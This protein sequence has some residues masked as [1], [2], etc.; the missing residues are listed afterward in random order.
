MSNMT[1]PFLFFFYLFTKKERWWIV[2]SSFSLPF[3][4]CRRDCHR[5]LFSLPFFPC[6][7]D[8]HRQRF[9]RS[10]SLLAIVTVIA[11]VFFAPFLCLPS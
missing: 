4:A 8:R 6:R 3:F 10:L 7:R 1:S 2:E 9:F 5:Q 11:S